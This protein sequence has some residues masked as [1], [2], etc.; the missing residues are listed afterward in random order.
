MEVV[1][2]EKAKI[3]L[4]NFSVYK[5][6]HY[7]IY[8]NKI[9][10][11]LTD[12]STKSVINLIINDISKKKKQKKIEPNKY[13]TPTELLLAI[14]CIELITDLENNNSNNIGIHNN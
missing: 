4:S 6:T 8:L 11:L 13:D 14:D 3:L 1:S 9:K 5:D 10:I 12:L 7:R 2:R